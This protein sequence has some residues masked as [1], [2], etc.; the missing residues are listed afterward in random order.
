MKD[1]QCGA[2]VV[3]ETDYGPRR[4]TIEEITVLGEDDE[5]AVFVRVIL[6]EPLRP[7]WCGLVDV[8]KA[9]ARACPRCLRGGRLVEQT[10]A[11]CEQVHPLH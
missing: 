8:A 10:L 6:D 11:T 4:G 1:P 2:R 9:P 5:R 7:C 3:V